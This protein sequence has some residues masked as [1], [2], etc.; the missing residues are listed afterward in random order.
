MPLQEEQLQAVMQ[1]ENVLS[2]QSN[3]EKSLVAYTL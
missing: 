2:L 3:L 1:I